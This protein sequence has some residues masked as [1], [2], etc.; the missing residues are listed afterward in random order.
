MTTQTIAC[1]A[2]GADVPYGR[3]SCPSCGELL[4]SVAGARRPAGKPSRAAKASASARPAPAEPTERPAETRDVEA[5]LPWTASADDRPLGATEAVAEAAERQGATQPS[6]DESPGTIDLDDD[7]ADDDDGGDLNGLAPRSSTT[8]GGDGP[9]TWAVGGG[10]AGSV[11]TRYM[12]RPAPRSADAGDVVGAMLESAPAGASPFTERPLF[13]P[14]TVSASPAVP[15]PAPGAYLPPPVIAPAGP[16]APARV[17]AGP[18][19]STATADHALPVS[20]DGAGSSAAS[21]RAASASVDVAR[22]TE[23]AGWLSVAGAAF[24]AVGFLLPWA[25]IVIGANGLSYVDRWGLAGQNHVLVVLGVLTVL[26]LGLVRNPVPVWVRAG[27]GGL[28]LGPLLLG[29]IWPYLFVAALSSGPGIPIVAVGA[30]AL[31]VAGVLALVADRHGSR[32][33]GV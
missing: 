10:L 5:E 11:T 18:A 28:G 22:I 12:P 7:L 6:G 9:A 17:W 27:I 26:V 13:A 16:P 25:R 29:L 14:A 31:I 8:H 24:A 21:P 30:V 32:A 15:T 2:C 3:L 33:P 20:V 23:F 19:T 4:A 1:S